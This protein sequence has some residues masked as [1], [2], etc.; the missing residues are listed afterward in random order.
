M[1][2]ANDAAAL[3]AHPGLTGREREGPPPPW[4]IAKM[5]I[6]D[7]GVDTSPRRGNQGQTST[8]TLDPLSTPRKEMSQQHL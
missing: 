2:E 4:G 3:A 8:T 7:A 5:P 6:N 1:R